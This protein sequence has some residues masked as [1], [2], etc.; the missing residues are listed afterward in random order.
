MKRLLLLRHAE[1]NLDFSSI[2]D[3]DRP[4][5][6]IGSSDAQLIGEK[7]TQE[8]TEIDFMLS[9]GANRA[10]ATAKVIAKCV[11]YPIKSIE[12]NNDIYNSSHNIMMNVINSVLDIYSS[13]IIAGHN[14][15]FH[16]LSQLLSDESLNEFPTCT[17]FCIEF[18]VDSWAQVIKGKKK[19][20]IFPELFKN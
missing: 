19:F 15:T 10:I 7:L 5:N 11:G 3:F 18:D 1:A 12:I 6:E 14:P 4:L 2:K 8:K 13:I 17:V 16:Y 9:S 20:M